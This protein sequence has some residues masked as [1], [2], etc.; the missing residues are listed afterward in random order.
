MASFQRIRH[1]HWK[2]P[3]LMVSSLVAGLILA[4]GHHVFYS[5]LNGSPAPA[6]DYD[7]GGWSIPKQQ[8][9]IAGGTAFAFLVK[10]SLV[11]AVGTAYIQTFWRAIA[12]RDIKLAHLDT[13]GS[14]PGSITA[15]VAI[16]RW[17]NF[18]LLLLLA[19]IIW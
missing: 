18:P 3:T 8:A 2:A 7:L 10:A 13:L 12:A 9:N 5:R 14:V 4:V 6:S 17:V 1:I 15:L 19:L 11:V 16:W